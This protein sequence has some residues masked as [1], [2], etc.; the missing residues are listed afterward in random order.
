MLIP[1]SKIQLY[2]IFFGE[3]L[4]KVAGKNAPGNSNSQYTS[5]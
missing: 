3:D 5:S 1:Q 4:H 2:T